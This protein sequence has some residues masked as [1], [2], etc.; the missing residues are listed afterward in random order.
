VIHNN[1]E[2]QQREDD[3][4]HV[5][6]SSMTKVWAANDDKQERQNKKKRMKAISVLFIASRRREDKWEK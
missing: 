2:K 4:L 3:G 5:H 1:H 6:P